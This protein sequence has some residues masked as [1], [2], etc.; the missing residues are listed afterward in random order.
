MKTIPR[1]E[2]IVKYCSEICTNLSD[3]NWYTMKASTDL[4]N[5]CY[6]FSFCTL[7]HDESYIGYISSQRQC[8]LLVENDP[9]MPYYAVT[10]EIETTSS[11]VNEFKN[12]TIVNVATTPKVTT[13]KKIANKKKQ[14]RIRPKIR[15]RWN[16][17]TSGSFLG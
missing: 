9:T 5:I 10:E 4:S 6:F 11:S 17:G 3:C 12:K 1:N 8:P 16:T 7:S 13:S 15:P 2:S 14:T